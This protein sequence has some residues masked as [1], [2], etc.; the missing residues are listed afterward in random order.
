MK[1]KKKKNDFLWIQ[2]KASSNNSVIILF[3]V[4]DQ[5]AS[6]MTMEK[7]REKEKDWPNNQ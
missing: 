7:K 3:K 1:K 4:A 6:P 2:A 5:V